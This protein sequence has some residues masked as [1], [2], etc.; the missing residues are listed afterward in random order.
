[1]SVPTSGSLSLRNIARERLYGSYG[2]GGT[3][4]GAVSMFD[5]LNGG[6]AGGSGD[7][8]PALNTNSCNPTVTGE[9]SSWYGYDQNCVT[10]YNWQGKVPNRPTSRCAPATLN[11]NYYTTVTFANIVVGTVIYT[12][13][14]GSAVL[15]SSDLIIVE[16]TTWIQTNSSGAVTSINSCP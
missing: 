2:G 4:T 8:Y 5:L 10:Y 7:D 16:N 15:A 3:I 6:Q 9:M 13:S 14:S 1:M 12:N 11:D